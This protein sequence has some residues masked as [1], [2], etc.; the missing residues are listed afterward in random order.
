MSE[1][2]EIDKMCWPELI[3]HARQLE[4]AVKNLIYIIKCVDE[5]TGNATS[6]AEIYEARQLAGLEPVS[7][8]LG[9]K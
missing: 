9:E 6:R 1:S 8:R 2:D 3:V 4:V 5:A 7:E